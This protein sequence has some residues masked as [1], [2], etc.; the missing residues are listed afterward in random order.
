ML[1][2][3]ERLVGESGWQLSHGERG[4]LFIARALLQR[5]DLRALHESVAVLDAET[6]ERVL[7]RVLSRAETVL[8]IARP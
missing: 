5:L 2:G 8:V 7:G 4:R 1:S 3:R 6:L